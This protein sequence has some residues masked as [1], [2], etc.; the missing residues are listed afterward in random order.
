[1]IPITLNAPFDLATF[2]LSHRITNLRIEQVE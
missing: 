2:E 1:V